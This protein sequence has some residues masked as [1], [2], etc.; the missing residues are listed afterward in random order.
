MARL[1]VQIPEGL[2]L[3]SEQIAEL[4]QKF[5]SQIV[6]SLQAKSGEIAAAAKAK[7]EVVHVEVIA[8]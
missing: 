8:I 2:G 5:G 7:A 4:R 6:E 3:T 1:I